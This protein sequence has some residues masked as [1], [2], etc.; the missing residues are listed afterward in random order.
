VTDRLRLGI[1]ARLGENSTE[2][3]AADTRHLSRWDV[4]VDGVRLSRL[5]SSSVFTPP[6]LRGVDPPYTVSRTQAVTDTGLTERLT[7]HSHTD[8]PLSV[9][10]EY[11]V[12][13]DFADQFEVR[14]GRAP[15]ERTVHA[16][17]TPG[18]L[19][20]RYTRK[21]FHRETSVRTPLEADIEAD[22]IRLVLPVAPHGTA[23]AQ[24]DVVVRA[25]V[26]DP[27]RLGVPDLDALLMPVSE[28]YVVAAGSPWFLTLFGRDSLL[29]ALFATASGVSTHRWLAA[30]TLRA[31]A[32]RQGRTLDR[33]RLEEPGKILHEVRV[34]ELSHFG[35]VPFGRYYGTVDATPLFLMLL[36]RLG[37]DDLAGELEQAARAAVDWMFT[38]GGLDRTGYLV[39]RTD[40]PGLV[41]QCWKDSPHGICFRSGEPATGEL[42]VCEVQGYAWAALRGTADLAERIWDDAGLADRLRTA[43]EELRTRFHREFWLPDQDYVAL[44][45]TTDGRLVDALSSNPGH[46]LWTGLL[47]GERARRVGKRLATPDFFTGWGIRTL[48]AGQPAYHPVSYHNGSVWPHDTAIAVAGL[49]SIGLPDEARRVADGLRDLALA[50]GGRLPEVLTGFSRSAEPEPV[51]YPHSCT[52]QAWAAA[53]PLLIAAALAPEPGLD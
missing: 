49:A 20:L 4:T 52:P 43:A 3:F 25:P 23:S 40:G 32:A 14:S 24:F 42:A 12:A 33:S 51:P 17:V 44:A 18:V 8:R 15:V 10:I 50:T 30:T 41:H 53:A 21:D 6:L 11:A 46:L 1:L 38:H 29:T 27:P 13:A 45:R 48:A 31:L 28:G 47:S 26:P 37:D 35:D 34:G 2:L 39:Y 5:G 36:A 7:V 19:L 16:S 9:L 22:R